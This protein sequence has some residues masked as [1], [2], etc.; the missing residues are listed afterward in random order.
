MPATVDDTVVLYTK[1][2]QKEISL[3][4]AVMVERPRLIFEV[5]NVE[6]TIA[7]ADFQR[8]APQGFEMS[9]NSDKFILYGGGNNYRLKVFN[10]NPEVTV[11]LT[12][13]IHDEH[14]QV[15]VFV[16]DSVLV[17]WFNQ[18]NRGLTIPYPRIVFHSVRDNGNQLYLQIESS[19][20][21]RAQFPD[22]RDYTPSIELIVE[23]DTSNPVVRHAIFG[24]EDSN[25]YQLYEAIVACSDRH[26]VESD[27]EEEQGGIGDIGG[28][29]ETPS[30]SFAGTFANGGDADDLE[31]S[32]MCVGDSTDYAAGMD[33]DVEYASIAGTVRPLGSEDGPY[34]MTKQRRIA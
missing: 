34:R 14:S 33:V 23:G 9:Q 30:L 28:F 3:A 20:L 31:A 25:M 5:P 13:G 26:P 2:E 8:S 32:D 22:Q 10:S 19:D 11:E 24:S 27:D 6:N 18:S 17:V 7:A 12:S 16:L 4:P 29:G 1:L 21:I 15:S